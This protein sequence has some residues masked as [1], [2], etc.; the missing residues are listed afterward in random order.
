MTDGRDT[1]RE[2]A[3]PVAGKWRLHGVVAMVAAVAVNASAQE[4]K[5]KRGERPR[6]SFK[7]MDAN[8]DGKLTKDEFVEARMKN[9]PEDRKERAKEF[10]KRMADRLFKDKKELSEEEYKAAREKMIEE[11]RK[12]GGKKREKK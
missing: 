4:K 6:M 10:V 5:K 11:W 7:D 3:R 9:V 8:K 2:K 12:K 1:I